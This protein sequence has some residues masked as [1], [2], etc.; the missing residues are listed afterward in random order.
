MVD[1]KYSSKGVLGAL[2][3]ILITVFGWYLFSALSSLMPITTLKVMFWIG[4]F[5]Y[6]ISAVFV[7]PLMMILGNEGDFKG[8]IKGIIVFVIGYI[9]SLVL[10]YTIPPIVETMDSIWPNST[11][12]SIA[13]FAIYS[14]W[15]LCLIIMPTIITLKGTVMPDAN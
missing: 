12:T 8:A 2:I 11:F 13:W 14:L 7:I 9:I 4:V 6:W 3:G 15:V 10:Y 5:L 1:L